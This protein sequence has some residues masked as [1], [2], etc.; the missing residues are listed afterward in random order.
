MQSSKS[1]SGSSRIS[2]TQTKDYGIKSV[3]AR[4]D[5]LKE[6]FGVHIFDIIRKNVYFLFLCHLLYKNHEKL[7]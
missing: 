6:S 2:I 3:V 7:R 1:F 5:E 4:R